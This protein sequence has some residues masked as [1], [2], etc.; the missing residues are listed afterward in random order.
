[1][2]D[3][4]EFKV[5]NWLRNILH[6]VVLSF[7]SLAAHA[8]LVAWD[9]NPPSE[10]VEGYKV[11]VTRN[12]VTIT[13]DVGN[14]TLAALPTLLGGE[15]YVIEVT[16][17]NAAG[18]SDRSLPLPYS[19]PAGA[20]PPTITQQPQD[21][22]PALGNPLNL[23]VQ[24]GG[25]TPHRF[26][27][28]RG[29]TPVGVN[30]STYSVAS[31]QNADAGAYRVRISNP[32]GV[33]TSA[34][35]NV[36]ISLAPTITEHPQSILNLVEGSLA[37]FT[38]AATGTGPFTYQW[39]K[40]IDNISGANG[41]TYTISSV[42]IGDAGQYSVRVSNGAGFQ[43]SLA[44]T[45]TVTPLISAI[46]PSFTSQPFSTNIAVGDSLVLSGSATGTAPLQFQWYKG[47]EPVDGATNSTLQF[48]SIA[49]A[50]Q[51]SYTLEVSNVADSITSGP[52]DVTVFVR[53]P[54]I[55]TDLA[56]Q[57]VL[58]GDLVHLAITAS[59][60]PPLQYTWYKGE[61]IISGATEAE[62]IFDALLTDSGQYQVVVANSAGSA[63]SLVAQVTVVER[64]EIDPPLIVLQPASQNVNSGSSVQFTVD[65]ISLESPTFQW[66]R[67]GEPILGATGPSYNITRVL[68]G[69]QGE[70][71]V[72]VGNSGGVETSDV[73][74]L[75][76]NSA[77]VVVSQPTDIEVIEGATASLVASA[78]GVG[79]VSFQWY[80]DGVPLPDA[81]ASTLT[82]S[83]ARP[84]D[85]GVYVALI[86]DSL[87]TIVG[88]PAT[89]KVI[90][91]P[92]IV[93][94]PAN[95]LLVLGSTAQFTVQASPAG[96][97]YEWLKNG[98]PVPNGS[99]ATLAL[100]GITEDDRASYSVRVS[101]AAG[102]VT[103]PSATLQIARPPQI[104]VQPV[105]G[106]ALEGQPFTLSVEAVGT[107]SLEY[108]WFRGASAVPGATS[109]VLSIA[110]ASQ[111]DV[112]SYT[113]VVRN[114]FGNVTSSP[115]AVAF[116]P[117]PVFTAQPQDT[118][119]VLGASG[120]LAAATEN[121][122]QFQWYKDGAPLPLQQS[123][124]LVFSAAAASDSGKYHVIAA[125]AAGQIFSRSA[126]VAILFPPVISSQPAGGSIVQGGSLT[127][128][129][130]A[131]G[132]EPLSYQ[133][134]KGTDLIA[135][136]TQS[137][138][139]VAD[140]QGSAAGNYTVRVSNSAGAVTS[141]PAQVTVIF[142]PQ[143]A[144]HPQSSTV[145]E[146][147]RSSFTL[148][149]QPSGTGPFTYRWFKD[150]VA[151][152]SAT[153]P[154]LTISN[155]NRTDAGV[156]RVEISNA[157]GSAVS[158]PA[159]LTVIIPPTV[160][161]QP[162]G[163]VVMEG[164]P[165]SLSVE[166]SGNQPFEFQWFR[167]NLAIPGATAQTYQVESATLADQGFYTV[168]IANAA[169]SI[170]SAP[171]EVV[172]LAAPKIVS[173][174]SDQ[175]IAPGT[176]FVLSVRASGTGPLKYQWL[177]EGRSLAGATTPNLIFLGAHPLDSGNY[178]VVVSGPIGTNT[179]AAIRVQVGSSVQPPPVAPVSSGTSVSLSLLGTL[180]VDS[181]SNDT[182]VL[183]FSETLGS[184]WT[185]IGTALANDQGTVDFSI[186]HEFNPRR[187]FFRLRK[188]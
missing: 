33:I 1:M 19:T 75:T 108:Q 143:L 63:T 14:V 173:L 31:A 60:S 66:L 85:A 154:E 35:A 9:P 172:V 7:T 169:G 21:A 96:V 156:Y 142:P 102:T 47:G 73:A 97:E 64:T 51:G 141:Q 50:D 110:T 57:S 160:V 87:G 117:L 132:T 151:I 69:H 104:T 188:Q 139:T 140:Q 37:Q 167:D 153:G 39:R 8:V 155:V 174:T 17:Y 171:V 131:T 103:S 181:H 68:P 77:P 5:K 76:V 147:S 158:D 23:N 92:T 10:G 34:V 3:R 52:A 149:A 112:G 176:D 83:N 81:T 184:A 135:G 11:Y 122:A 89:V 165:L 185:D 105:G 121:A 28:F 65:A 179:S 56:S 13:N 82:I 111:N 119:I 150:D 90:A 45:L 88:A 115:A 29:T 146:G 20:V 30:S 12:G 183:Q 161:R 15:N 170:A 71:T 134:F 32:V 43:N 18:E 106:T 182:Y 113:V 86:S 78:Q 177:R 125:N 74:L 163:A 120:A 70:Y 38:V 49:Q 95:V 133:W 101:N 79:N 152:P 145:N 138:L 61:D 22:T 118:Q 137:N 126:N 116:V 159:V 67:N 166:A 114:A 93:T 53:P 130:A 136:A 144:A 127:L 162:L 55:L 6:L 59:G 175:T 84:S 48:T 62:L 54:A 36:S 94:P 4:S 25:T 44:A 91:R 168:R 124:Q 58:E 99:G 109:R 186:T 148:R 24:V 123:S 27:W 128:Q 129:V 80:K 72:R 42:A 41:S 187:G 26:D 164:S 16:A 46:P 180:R 107:E 100:P 40:G 157:A 2:T 178:S 98:S